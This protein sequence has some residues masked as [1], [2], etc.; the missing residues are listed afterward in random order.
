MLCEFE[1]PE[2]IGPRS[3]KKDNYYLE[4]VK[5]RNG[6]IPETFYHE[7]EDDGRTAVLPALVPSTKKSLNSPKLPARSPNI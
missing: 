2:R 5:L 1:M 6:F 7:S 3:G 4:G